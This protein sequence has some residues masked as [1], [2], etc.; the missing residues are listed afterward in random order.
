MP[1]CFK[2]KNTLLESHA[3]IKQARENIQKQAWQ[4]SWEAKHKKERPTDKVSCIADV[5]LLNKRD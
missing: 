3:Y 2:L 1:N 4:Q 5:K